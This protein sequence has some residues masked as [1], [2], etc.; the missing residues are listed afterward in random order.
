VLAG[1]HEHRLAQLPA[2]C[3][4]LACLTGLLCLAASHAQG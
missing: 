1:Q 4:A 3:A 2:E